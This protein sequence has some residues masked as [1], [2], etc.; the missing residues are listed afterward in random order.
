MING[1]KYIYIIYLETLK[2]ICSLTSQQYL[3]RFQD[4]S[5]FLDNILNATVGE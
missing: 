1:I 3:H 5:L 4:G 2:Y